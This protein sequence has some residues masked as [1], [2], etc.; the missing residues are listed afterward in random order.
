MKE[1]YENMELLF[2]KIQY[3]R[4]NWNTCGDLRVTATLLALQLGYQSFVV[5][6]VSELVMREHN[7][8]SK[9]S[10]LIENRLLQNRKIQ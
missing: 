7:R 8:T 1:Y 3:E 9:E 5:Y 4:Y 2:E 6:C 10:G